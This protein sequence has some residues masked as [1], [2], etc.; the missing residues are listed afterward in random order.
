MNLWLIAIISSKFQGHLVR[1]EVV[2]H[3]IPVNDVIKVVDIGC[4]DITIVNI[5]GMFPN[6]NC[7]KRLIVACE[8]I[9][10]IRSV[11]NGKLT[12]TFS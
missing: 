11:K 6:I 8:W 4:S 2:I 12:L 7:Q 9:S 10:C 3:K 1:L 5:V